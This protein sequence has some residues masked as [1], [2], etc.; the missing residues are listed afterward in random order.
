MP[1]AFFDGEQTGDLLSLLSSD[2]P[3]LQYY[4]NGLLAQTGVALS[5][6]DMDQLQLTRHKT[7]P[8]WNYTL[9]PRHIS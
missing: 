8:D 7:H 3:A 9:S 5:K 2:I 4:L 6:K 1:H